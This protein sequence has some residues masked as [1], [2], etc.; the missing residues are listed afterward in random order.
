MRKLFGNLLRRL[1]RKSFD[2]STLNDE[3]AINTT[4]ERAQNI[5]INF[6]YF[7]LENSENGQIKFVLANDV[8]TIIKW[9][10]RVWL[11]SFM[12]LVVAVIFMQKPIGYINL[13]IILSLIAIFVR[14]VEFYASKSFTF[15]KTQNKLSK[16]NLKSEISSFP[17][18][19][20]HA[21]QLIYKSMGTTETYYGYELNLVFNDTSRMYLVSYDN[22]HELQMDAEKLSKFLDVPVW[23]AS[24]FLV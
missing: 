4:W 23:D 10:Y 7:S 15:D 6:P 19:S 17:L 21:L 3:I 20:I 2:P 13:F 9:V 11:F 8:K 1:E 14:L 5:D 12:A 16:E 18:D 22:Q 24:E